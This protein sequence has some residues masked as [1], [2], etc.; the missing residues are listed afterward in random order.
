MKTEV[1]S[2]S[3]EEETQSIAEQ[4]AR[5]LRSG[6][7]VTISGDLGVGKTEFVRGI[8]RFFEVE[9]IVTSPTFSI[10]NVYRGTLTTGEPVQIIH[11]DLYR[12]KNMKELSSIGLLEWL[13]LPDA[14]KVI[15]WPEKAN[16]I[17]RSPHYQVT[18]KTLPSLDDERRQIHI[19]T[20][21]SEDQTISSQ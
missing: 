6:D 20:S 7:I 3:S 13:Q 8:C 17:I 12:L 10:I 5:R 1:Y 14:I 16:G 11:I 9:D 15:E 4:F 2:S 18:I 21:T 19:T